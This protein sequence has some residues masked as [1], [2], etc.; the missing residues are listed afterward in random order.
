MNMTQASNMKKKSAPKPLN[1]FPREYPSVLNHSQTRLADQ[2]RIK[3]QHTL[4]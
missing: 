4:N 1:E 2:P 3:C